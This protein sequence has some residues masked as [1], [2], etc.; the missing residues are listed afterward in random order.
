MSLEQAYDQKRAECA[1]LR[2]QLT[3]AERQ[4]DELVAALRYLV[5]A[6]LTR[7]DADYMKRQMDEAV[8]V[9]ALYGITPPVPYDA[10]IA[11][12]ESHES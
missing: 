4:R 9:L 2:E 12:G 5:E 8:R 10:A 1:S 3:K 11:K 6:I 7:A